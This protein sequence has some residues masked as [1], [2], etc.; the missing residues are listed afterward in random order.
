MSDY[1]T[2]QQKIKPAEVF[3]SL[4]RKLVRIKIMVDNLSSELT[5][6]ELGNEL[7]ITHQSVDHQIQK[8]KNKKG[9]SK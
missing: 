7:G 9:Q 1:T 4:V 5:A 3:P 8:Q 6:Q 2:N